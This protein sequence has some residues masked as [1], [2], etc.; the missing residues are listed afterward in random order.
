MIGGPGPRTKPRM[1]MPRLPI[2]SLAAALVALAMPAA[3]LA[4]IRIAV[5]APLSGPYQPLGQEI[6]AGAAKAVEDINAA[7]GIGGEKLRLDTTDDG[8]RPDNAAGDAT[9]AAAR[10]TVFVVGHV[11]AAAAEAAAD[12]YA[13]KGI[14]AITPAVTDDGFTDHRPGPAILR[15]AARDDAQ[16]AAAGAFLARTYGKQRIAI[17]SDGSPYGR[18]LA[19][20]V[21]AGLNAAG[22]KEARFDSFAPGAKDYGGLVDVMIDDGIGVLFVA[23]Y[24]ADAALIATALKARKARIVLMGGDALGSSEFAVAA[25]DA[26]TGTLFTGFTDWRAAPAA[27]K[28]A[29]SLS[30]VGTEPRNFVLPSYAAVQLF[31]AARA[32][33][34]SDK[35]GDLAGWL[36]S[37][38]V[39]TVIGP[40]AFD[41]KGDAKLP[42]FT[43]Y[44]WDGDSYAPLPGS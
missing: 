3:A 28:V 25:G 15:L 16:G 22:V 17:L 33:T 26:A 6:K 23:G 4:D 1:T 34:S 24:D 42:G 2:A 36:G 35:G 12:V 43:V 20:S 19:E 8:C 7:G 9:K 31:A 14:L 18:A 44:R 39:D 11:C 27:A 5:I 21:Q 29:A 40:V 38:S 41:A 10:G 32:A 30:A 37:H 13:E